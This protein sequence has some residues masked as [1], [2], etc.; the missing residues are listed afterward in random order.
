[1]SN[2]SRPHYGAMPVTTLGAVIFSWSLERLP[3]CRAAAEGQPN[4][5]QKSFGLI[6]WSNWRMHNVEW[7]VEGDKLIVTID[8]S[9]ESVEEAP[10]SASGKTYLVASTGSAMPGRGACSGS[11]CGRC[12]SRQR[13]HEKHQQCRGP[14]RCDYHHRINPPSVLRSYPSHTAF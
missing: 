14:D 7:K 1:M 2:D 9:K 11:A 6:H 4:D 3:W 13:F 12:G 10:P 5:S 8:I